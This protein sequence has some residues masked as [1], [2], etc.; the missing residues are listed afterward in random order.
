M[1][2]PGTRRGQKRVSE[3]LE[4]EFQRVVSS[5]VNA[6]IGIQDISKSSEHH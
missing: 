3:P 4:L 1:C 5:Y 6:E 2:L